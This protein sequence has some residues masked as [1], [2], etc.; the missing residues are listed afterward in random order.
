VFGER[1]WIERAGSA[2]TDAWQRWSLFTV[3]DRN[4]TPTAADTSLLMLPT[5]PKVQEGP[6]LEEVLMIRDEMANMVWGVEKTIPAA[7]GQ[8]RLGATA[9]RETREYHER[10]VNA[11]P[12]AAASPLLENDARIRYELM[13]AVP[14][15]WIPFIAVRA[16]GSQRATELQRASMPR[17]IKG[18]P[19]RPFANV[20]PCTSLLRPGLDTA[21]LS[22]FLVPEEEVPRSGARLLLKFR[23]ARGADGRVH[24]WLGVQK[25]VGRGEGSGGLAFDGLV[26]SP[27]PGPSS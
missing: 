20:K 2:A 9:G 25:Q 7:D 22:P 15:H 8:G 16:S 19:V 21:Y 18:D 1:F 3:D 27:G 4:S 5:V 11:G 10:L 13:S 14:E 12:A 23:R 24:V 17:V 26:N 6:L